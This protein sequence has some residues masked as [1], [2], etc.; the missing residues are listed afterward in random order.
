MEAEQRTNIVQRLYTKSWTFVSR[1]A[2]R[3]TCVYIWYRRS[4]MPDLCAILRLVMDGPK[5][6][7]SGNH[8]RNGIQ[9]V[10]SNV[11]ANV[12]EP[13]LDSATHGHMDAKTCL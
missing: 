1:F 13:T 7:S 6:I 4:S 12:P 2:S 3:Q 5:V 8:E 9:K 10:E 11:D